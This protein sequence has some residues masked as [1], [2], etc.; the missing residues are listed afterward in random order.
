MRVV[1]GAEGGVRRSGEG[2]EGDFVTHSDGEDIEQD[3]GGLD[4]G[5]VGRGAFVRVSSR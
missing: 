2:R 4:F 1:E 5:V 3:V